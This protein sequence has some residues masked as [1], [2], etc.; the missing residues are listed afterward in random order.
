MGTGKGRG[1]GRDPHISKKEDGRKERCFTENG[2]RY[3]V[4]PIDREGGHENETFPLPGDFVRHELRTKD[5]NRLVEVIRTI[6]GYLFSSFTHDL[7]E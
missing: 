2:H 3:P 5:C 1:R 4:I 7:S 6:S